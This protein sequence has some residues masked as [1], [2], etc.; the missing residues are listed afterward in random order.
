[1]QFHDVSL[2]ALFT[3]AITK[4]ISYFKRLYIRVF[5]KVDVYA[6][7]I[8][9]SINVR[10]KYLFG[11]TDFSSLNKSIHSLLVLAALVSLFYRCLLYMYAVLLVRL[12]C[13]YSN[14]LYNSIP[15]TYYTCSCLPH[16]LL[17]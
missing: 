7:V 1:M 6:R 13:L 4:S 2:C 10:C 9:F 8:C 12:A 14:K 15:N 17:G 16:I 11:R 3:L 5:R